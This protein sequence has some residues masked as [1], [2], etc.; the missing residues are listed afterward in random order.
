MAVTD[1][2]QDIFEHVL[3]PVDQEEDARKTSQQLARYDPERV[4]AVHVAE[5]GEGRPDITPAKAK[6]E[7]GEA[8]INVV[9]E[10]FPDAEKRLASSKNIPKRIFEIADEVGATAI[11]YRP[12]VDSRLMRVLSEDLSLKLVTRADRPVVTLPREESD[13]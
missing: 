2:Q 3:V 8:A 1:G 10:A 12:L 4:T 7:R 9:Q 11:V 6:K 13:H 5:V